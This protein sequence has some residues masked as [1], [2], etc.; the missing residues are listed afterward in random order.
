M[1]GA[2]AARCGLEPVLNRY[3]H[4]DETHAAV[5]AVAEV[6]VLLLL[7]LQVL[8]L[9]LHVAAVVAAGVN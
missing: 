5:A 6:H 9:L 2:G 3:Q 4:R 1:L 7:L 8:M